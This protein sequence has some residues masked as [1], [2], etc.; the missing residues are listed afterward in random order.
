MCRCG[1]A[2]RP[3]EREPQASEG[4]WCITAELNQAHCAWFNQRRFWWGAAPDPFAGR[5]QR[6]FYGTTSAI[7]Y[8]RC[9]AI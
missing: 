4:E 7:P 9:G 8:L 3:N 6:L 5:E 1:A 2:E